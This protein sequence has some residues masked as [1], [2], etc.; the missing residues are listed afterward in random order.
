MVRLEVDK[1]YG[2]GDGAG[3]WGLEELSGEFQPFQ[4][5]YPHKLGVEVSRLLLGLRDRPGAPSGVQNEGPNHCFQHLMLAEGP[6]GSGVQGKV[7]AAGQGSF[8]PKAG[9]PLR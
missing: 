1:S 3:A 9:A 7:C 4:Q 2:E 6:V 8:A 5:W